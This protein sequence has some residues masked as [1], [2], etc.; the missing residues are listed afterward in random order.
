[1]QIYNVWLLVN[2][3]A[4]AVPDLH[5]LSRKH[6]RTHMYIIYIYIY[7][8]IKVN[9]K[10]KNKKFVL[11]QATKNHGESRGVALLFL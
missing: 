8:Y 10:V 5:R 2:G 3:N 4:P 7:I 6:A 1:M 9:V 11:Q